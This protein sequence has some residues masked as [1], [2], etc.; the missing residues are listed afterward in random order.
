MR[1]L[2][3][4]LLFLTSCGIGGES[5]VL[6]KVKAFGTGYGGQTYSK[7]ELKVSAQDINPPLVLTKVGPFYSGNVVSFELSVPKGRGRK[8]EVFLYTKDRLLFYGSKVVDILSDYTTLNLNLSK[9]NLS[10]LNAPVIFS[11][12][13]KSLILE[14]D[15]PLSITVQ[16]LE[17][18]KG[19]VFLVKDGCSKKTLRPKETCFITLRASPLAPSVISFNLSTDYGKFKLIVNNLKNYI[20]IFSPSLNFYLLPVS[21]S[22]SSFESLNLVFSSNVSLRDSSNLSYNVSPTSYFI[23]LSGFTQITYSNLPPKYLYLKSITKSSNSTNLLITFKLI[24]TSNT[25]LK[26]FLEGGGD[27][28]IKTNY[29]KGINLSPNSSCSFNLSY[30]RGGYLLVDLTSGTAY[31]SFVIKLYSGFLVL[32]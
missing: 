25:S 6:V 12:F 28:F 9:V 20:G 30:Q 22:S 17:L 18:P 8:F 29:C 27:V 10:L 19:E 15:S 23:P 7:V 21:L 1:L 32:Y 5:K 26:A 31:T 4:I 14:N 2:V 24:N 3:L 11:T 13:N 16:G